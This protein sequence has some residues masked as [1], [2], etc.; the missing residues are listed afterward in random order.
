MSFAVVR[1]LAPR[2]VPAV[3]HYG[4]SHYP[5]FCVTR[6]PR[7][8]HW[9]HAGALP[10]R[11]EAPLRGRTPLEPIFRRTRGAR[12]SAVHLRDHPRPL[13]TTFETPFKPAALHA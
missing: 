2:P 10:R 1:G 9:L 11:R 13:F 4:R 7:P 8:L 12:C 6:G 5:H 3:Y